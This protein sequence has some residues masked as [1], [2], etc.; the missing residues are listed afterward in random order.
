MRSRGSNS[1]KLDSSLIVH[2]VVTL[3]CVFGLFIVPPVLARS[4]L[5]LQD[6]ITVAVLHICT[7]AV[8]SGTNCD[9][10]NAGAPRISN[11]TLEGTLCQPPDGSGNRDMAYGCGR[12]GYPFNTNPVS[13][14]LE[15]YVK[16]VVPNELGAGHPFEAIKA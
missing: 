10:T 4:M 7:N 15:D 2:A 12:N 11:S 1:I 13:L 6:T 14:E 16:D 5:A 8:E 3:F 9:G